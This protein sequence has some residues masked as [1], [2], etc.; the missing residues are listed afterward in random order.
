M[1]K[2]G[3]T[4]PMLYLHYVCGSCTH[5]ASWYIKHAP[6]TEIKNADRLVS[7]NLK[8]RIIHGGQPNVSDMGQYSATIPRYKMDFPCQVNQIAHHHILLLTCRKSFTFTIA[9]PKK[10]AM[11]SNDCYELKT[12]HFY[13]VHI[14]SWS[15]IV[16][17]SNM[18]KEVR[19]I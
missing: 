1:K 11:I 5:F 4:R 2:R 10:E 8:S 14:K 7:T 15:C 6:K 3:T 12:D 17:R 16:R 19:F 13:Q 18:T 9:T